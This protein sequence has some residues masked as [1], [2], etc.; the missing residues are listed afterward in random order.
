MLRSG[1]RLLTVGVAAGIALIS[2]AA[3]AIA[4]V[5]VTV[6]DFT[7]ESF[8]GDYYLD[9]DDSG[10][11]TTRV[12]EHIV[13]R[14]PDFDQNR[15]IIRAIPLRDGEVPLDVQMISVTDET[16]AP[17]HYER[18]DYGDFA[19]FALGTDAYLHGTQ[20]FVL[21]Y[22]LR[23]TIRYFTDS[24]G[25]EFYWDVNGTG[26]AQPFQSV[27][28]RIHLSER[29]S[30]A[31][32]G[33]SACY[34]GYYSETTPCEL[35][36]S[37][38]GSQFEVTAQQVNPYSTVT[39]A[40]GF[41]SG[42]VRQPELPRDSWIV[43]TAPLVLASLL[44]LVLVI[45]IVFRS[46]AWRE[47][48]GRGFI[49][50]QYEAPEGVHVM[51]AAD[52]IGRS[53]KAFPAQLIDFAVRGMI[54]IVDAEPGGSDSS[55]R[56]ELE[57]VTS[58]E[59]TADELRVLTL[60][61]G[62]GPT[63]GERV[64]PGTLKAK[65]GAAL[66]SLQTG[67]R[68]A[69]TKAGLRSKP[70]PSVLPRILRR[71][72]FWL[73]AAFVPV[74]IWAIGNDVFEQSVVF[75]FTLLGFVFALLVPIV[76]VRPRL[77]SEKGALVRDHLLGVREYLT[78][79]E[80]DRIRMLQSPAGAE[81]TV[82]HPIDP[83]DPEAIVA[84]YERLLPHAV[85]WGVE[86]YWAELLRARYQTATPEWLSASS[87]DSSMFRRFSTAA[88]SHVRPIA[89]PS[90]SSSTWSGSSGSSSSSGSSGG[91]FSG[92]GGGGGGGGGR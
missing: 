66:Y 27:T 44:A 53:S 8:T 41:E 59:A 88:T 49:V 42:T 45:A 83:D 46:I 68:D 78:V 3:T 37:G 87:F 80:E 50:A 32:T 9:V 2:P 10:Y 69:A 79:A 40:I 43:T 47:P 51:L 29:L 62:S 58:D 20:T 31:L 72:A 84:L 77:L 30:D 36:G 25:D 67:L 23:N 19:E 34:H 90:S 52:V 35:T 7:F 26:W 22:D 38:D 12:V 24:G 70:S 61:F 21:E 71:T 28:A 75:P 11:A 56:F 18:A 17:V 63:P 4:Q 15:G 65:T 85:L 81:R 16:G 60:L 91:G 92:G 89:T 14:F 74:W 73:L 1:W 6:Q 82:S 5:P 55:T 86:E 39:V 57:F 54:N 13:A 76:L 64:N 33:D 48:R